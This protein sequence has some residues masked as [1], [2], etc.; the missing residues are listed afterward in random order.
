MKRGPG[1]S[2]GYHKPL[3][4][5]L[6]KEPPAS[7]LALRAEL[8]LP[9]NIDIY[10]AG[11]KGTSF[12]D[13]IG[14]IAAQL[15]IALDG[16]YEPDKLCEVLV[17]AM[18]ARGKFASQPHLRAQGLVAVELEERDGEVEI[19]EVKDEDGIIIA[20]EMARDTLPGSASLVKETEATD[21]EKDDDDVA[22][23]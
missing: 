13:C 23:H 5:L 14:I 7:L 10:Q 18:R 19:K 3:P 16:D 11:I 2:Y 9:A 21:S 6:I 4:T 15:D 12:E 22:I 20:G 1:K 17:E 8:A